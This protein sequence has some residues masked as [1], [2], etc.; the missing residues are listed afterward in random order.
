[1]LKNLCHVLQVT[2]AS[3]DRV[4]DAISRGEFSDFEDCLQ[5]ECAQEV[6]ADFIVTRNVDDFKHSRVK[7]IT[8]EDFLQYPG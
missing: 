1:M 3:H 6:F 7:A 2:G 5:D 8:P 4:C